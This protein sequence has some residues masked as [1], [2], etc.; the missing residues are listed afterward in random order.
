MA[1][2]WGSSWGTAWADSWGAGVQP[3]IVVV[4][5]ETT[6][7]AGRGGGRRHGGYSDAEGWSRD[8]RRQQERLA[9][10]SR[11]LPRKKDAKAVE[12]AARTVADAIEQIEEQN[13]AYYSERLLGALGAAVEAKEPREIVRL[14]K[15]AAEAAEQALMEMLAEALAEPPR[16]EMTDWDRAAIL[17]LS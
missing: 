15:A 8:Y 9:R 12:K 3:P 4:V 13:P 10:S 7:G 6:S 11:D 1:S 16:Y 2:A 14:S 17:L 5:P